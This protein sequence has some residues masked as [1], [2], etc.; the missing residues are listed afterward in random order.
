MICAG[1]TRSLKSASVFFAKELDADRPNAIAL[2]ALLGP[3]PRRRLGRLRQNERARRPAGTPRRRTASP[4][5]P[6][7]PPRARTPAAPA[8]SAK[9]NARPGR[10][11]LLD[12]EPPAR[13]RLQRHLELA[14]AKAAPGT[15][16]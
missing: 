6:P 7:A 11:E 3:A 8:G 10:A 12:D 14:P 15:A 16:A 9:T 2:G 4:A 5:A 1:R 13:R